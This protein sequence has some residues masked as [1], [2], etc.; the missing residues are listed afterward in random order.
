M[1]IM[2]YNILGHDT[3]KVLSVIEVAKLIEPDFLAIQEANSF[4]EKDSYYL[5][6]FSELLNL[7]Y[8]DLSSSEDNYHVASFS[9]YPF[10]EVE[11]L[12][13]F[14][15]ACLKTLVELPF[16]ETLIFNTHLTPFS[17]G[18]QL[19]E[20]AIL[21]GKR[22]LNTPTIILGDLNSLSPDDNY[23]PEI[24][25]N[26]NESQI[27]KF[28]SDGI[29]EYRVINELK[30]LGF[31]DA[32]LKIGVNSQNT[33]PTSSNKDVAHGIMR[34]DYIFMSEE[35]VGYLKGVEVIKNEVTEKA[36]DHYPVIA[37]LD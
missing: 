16:G 32:A 34:L 6:L 14:R 10:K 20:L 7:P 17:E 19:K 2:T 33:V 24:I 12:P 9:S 28:T 37:E 35:L 5:K 18:D 15:N 26:F 27:Y 4:L 3:E 22:I 30:M 36:S 8:Y 21:L 29:L 25:K 1:K 11:K 13:M 31:T 23:N